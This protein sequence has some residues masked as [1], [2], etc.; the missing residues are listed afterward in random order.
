MNSNEARLTR[1]KPEDP[2]LFVA[3]GG[4]EH[5]PVRRN[6]QRQNVRL[7]LHELEQVRIHLRAEHQPLF[8]KLKVSLQPRP[9]IEYSN[10][11]VTGN[12][13]R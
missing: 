12:S 3:R 7:V 9:V 4:R 2:Y 8:R 13:T 6:C 5:F 1:D 10:V 11:M